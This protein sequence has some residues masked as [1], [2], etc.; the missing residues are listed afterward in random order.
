MGATG[1]RAAT[2]TGAK[3][4][5]VGQEGKPSASRAAFSLRLGRTLGVQEIFAIAVRAF[6][7]AVDHRDD[8]PAAGGEKGADAVQGRAS[9]AL[10]LDHAALADQS[11]AHFELGL[12]QD[13]QVGAL[14]GQAQGDRQDL[15]QTDETGVADNQVGASGI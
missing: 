6:D 2:A 7:R 13:D 1:R 14:R 12:D 5:A 15:S 4:S 3:R 8:P 10:I 9:R 11:P